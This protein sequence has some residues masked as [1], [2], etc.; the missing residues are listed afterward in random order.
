MRICVIIPSYNEEKTI[1]DLVKEISAEGLDILVIDDGSKDR[2]AE[3]AKAS[4]AHVLINNENEGKGAT[5]KRG[6]NYATN[7]KYDAVIT[8][9]ADGQHDPRDLKPLI[10]EAKRR[11]SNLVVGNRMSFYKNMPLIRILTNKFMSLV[12]SLMC[13]QDVPDT[14]CGYRFISTDIL[15]KIDLFTSNFE[16]ESEVLVQAAKK[17]YRID[18][19]PI[20]T[21]YAGQKSQINPFVDTFRFIRFLIKHQ[22]RR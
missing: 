5:L 20:K 6:F 8:M 15:K 7:H 9:D 18:S 17:G 1:G 3:L 19:F 13:Q 4:G 12:I 14:Q 2:T 16:I 11:K 21:I 10:D 22:F